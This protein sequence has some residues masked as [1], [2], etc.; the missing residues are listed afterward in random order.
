MLV[1]V[2]A[3]STPASFGEQLLPTNGVKGCQHGQHGRRFHI[4]TRVNRT[5]INKTFINETFINETLVNNLKH[6]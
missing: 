4:C 1:S 3:A 2:P 6:L 5:F